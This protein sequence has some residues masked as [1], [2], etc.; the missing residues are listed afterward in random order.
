MAAEPHPIA[1]RPSRT[2]R[3]ATAGLAATAVVH[4]AALGFR[5]AL[6]AARPAPRAPGPPGPPP[7]PPP[8]YTVLVALRGEA[9]RVPTLVAALA[10]LDHP[11]ERLEVLLLLEHD[12][13][14]TRAAAAAA[15]AAH[16]DPPWLRVEVVPPGGPRTKPNALNHGLARARGELLVVYDAEDLPDPAQLRRA[17]AAFAARPE[18][19][20]LQA[21]PALV[22][23][24]RDPL[25]RLMAA[26]Y[27]LWHGRV[28]PGLVRLGAPVPLAGTSNHLRVG[29]LRRLGGWDAGNLTEDAELGLRLARAGHVTALLDSVTREDSTPPGVR[30]WV[31]QRSRWSQGYLQTWW[32]MVRTPAVPPPGMT[33][34]GD[35]HPAPGRLRPLQAACAHGI[36]LGTVALQLTTPVLWGGGAL[37][38]AAPA[39][40]LRRVGRRTLA[41][42]SA[43]GAA[44]AVALRLAAGPVGAPLLLAPGYWALE[45]L[46]AWRALH[47]LVAHPG[48]WERTPHPLRPPRGGTLNPAAP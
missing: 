24:P 6:A 44:R 18:V 35:H 38:A 8:R 10:R 41:V 26:E 40:A 19:V 32:G 12:D 29:A 33:R 1:A 27:R 16:G 30:A 2:G 21:R 42:A 11:R 17:A 13:G 23:E 25:G 36:L 31:R 34:T 7:V 45:G 15:R 20:C 3:V 47:A 22:A 28:I 9:E 39:P 46:A 48:R 4:L 5:L 14:P 43:A 37:A